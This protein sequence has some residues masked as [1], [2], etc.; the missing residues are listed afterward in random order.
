MAKKAEVAVQ[1]PHNGIPDYM[2]GYTKAKIGNIDVTDLVIP[3]V[4]LL[5]ALS[6]ELADFNN[7]KVGT[8][9]HTIANENMGSELLAVPI[10]IKKSYVLWSPRND[11]RGILA[12]A[13]DGVH[14]DNPNAE[15][16]VKPKGSANS[17]IYKLAATVA[18]SGL[19]EFGSSIPGDPQSVPAASLTYNMLWY[20]PE[21]PELSPSVIIN[22]RSSIKP[23][24]QLLSK[25]EAKPIAHYG[26]MYTIGIV[27][28]KGAEGPYFN[29]TYSGA[30]FVDQDTI[31]ITES[32][33]HRYAEAM[34][35]P[36]EESVDVPEEGGNGRQRRE[37]TE[38]D[39]QKY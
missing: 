13:M 24:Q 4:K 8:F 19:A 23:M 27:Q 7:A 2:K 3:R 37:P 12:R 14:W 6:P 39:N 17:V 1:E 28:Q 5:Q 38:A 35:T 9:W 26:Q 32:L 33:Y 36:N 20:F 30:G 18:E 22:T 16:T 15:F 21:F 34:W 10:V 31:K 11:D 29:F 25:I